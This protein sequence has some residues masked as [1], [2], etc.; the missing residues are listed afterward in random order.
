MGGIHRLAVALGP[1]CTSLPPSPSSLEHIRRYGYNLVR[2]CVFQVKLSNANKQFSTRCAIFRG[3]RVR[4]SCVLAFGSNSGGE[5]EL[6]KNRSTGD[7]HQ[8][9]NP[10]SLLSISCFWKPDL[11]LLVLRERKLRPRIFAPRSSQS[12]RQICKK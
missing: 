2:A 10:P 5:L 12:M 11:S 4:F 7:P 9:E 1:Y 6:R 8:T 3:N